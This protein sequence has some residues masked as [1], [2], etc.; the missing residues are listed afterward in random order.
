V[1]KKEKQVRPGRE[2]DTRIAREVFGHVV[3]ASNKMINEKAGEVK[4]PLRKYSK[5]MEWAWEVAVRARITLLPVRSGEWFAFAAG[6][7][8]WDSP[9]AFADFLLTGDFRSCGAALSESAPLAICEAALRALEKQ[10]ADTVL[11]M[12]GT[13]Q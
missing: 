10:Q 6:N 13:L 4:R 7:E 5:E 12:E 11:P 1:H 8:G 2:I 9:Q 3:W